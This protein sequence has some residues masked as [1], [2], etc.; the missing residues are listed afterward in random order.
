MHDL[1]SREGQPLLVDGY[2]VLEFVP[3]V[4]IRDID[5]ELPDDVD[6]FDDDNDGDDDYDD[7]D[8]DDDDSD[9]S[10]LSVNDYHAADD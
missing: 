9:Y 1:A 5:Q 8:H 2:P 6:Y 7:D 4:P 10:Y 3:G